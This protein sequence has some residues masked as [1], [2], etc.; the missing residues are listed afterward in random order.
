MKSGKGT[1]AVL[2]RHRKFR[3]DHPAELQRRTFTVIVKMCIENL[4]EHSP[5]LLEQLIENIS[6]L[7]QRILQRKIADQQSRLPGG[8]GAEIDQLERMHPLDEIA[9][10]GR[11]SLLNVDDRPG[12]RSANRHR[13]RDSADGKLRLQLKLLLARSRSKPAFRFSRVFRSFFS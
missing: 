8:I 5:L 1:P 7:P 2:W 4:H 11:R 3:G 6:Q 12:Q 10:S 13:Q 9:D